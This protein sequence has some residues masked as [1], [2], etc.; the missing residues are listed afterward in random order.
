MSYVVVFWNLSD[1]QCCIF[2]FFRGKSLE[3]EGVLSFLVFGGLQ[4]FCGG[5]RIGVWVRFIQIFR[6]QRIIVD[7]WVFYCMGCENKLVKLILELFLK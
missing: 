4:K 1:G 6:G 7:F 3:L 2:G 5:Y